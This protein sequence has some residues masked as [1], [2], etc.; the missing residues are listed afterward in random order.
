MKYKLL[1]NGRKTTLLKEFIVHADDSFECLSTSEITEDIACHFKYFQPDGYIFCPDYYS[2]EAANHIMT[3]KRTAPFSSA[4]IFLMGEPEVCNTFEERMPD[5][6][7]L[8]FRRPIT[9]AS[10]TNQIVDFFENKEKEEKQAEL[11]KAA[12][13]AAEK[14]KLAEMLAQQKKH[15]LI[16]DDDRSILKLLKAG[17]EN[18]YDVTTMVSG[19]MAQKFLET[20]T[21]DIILLDYEMPLENGP[22][23]FMKLRADERLVNVP[24]VF[25]T[26][27]AESSKIREVLALKPQGY[28]LKP[29]DIE[30][31]KSTINEILG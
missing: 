10:V 15:V 25:L 29:I 8:Y 21:T 3:M 1:I 13:Q 31:L 26:G 9:I 18:E 19:R 24:I 16:I 12:Q 23:V 11:M 6:I 22:E 5:I 28:L 7:S 20:K 17:L 14:Q 27:V 4:P 2:T 30:R